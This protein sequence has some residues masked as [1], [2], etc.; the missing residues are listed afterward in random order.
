MEDQHDIAE[1]DAV[2]VAQPVTL[3]NPL[4]VDVGAVAALEVFDKELAFS[5][6]DLGMLPAYR[7]GI[8]NDVTFGIPPHDGL[9]PVQGIGVARVR[10]FFAMRISGMIDVPLL[11]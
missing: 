2:V 5:L 9:L 3:A 4:A 11:P 10:A 6:L 1:R 7:E 8:E